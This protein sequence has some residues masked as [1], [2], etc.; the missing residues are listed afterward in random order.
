MGHLERMLM[1]LLWQRGELN[2]RQALEGVDRPLAYTTV[3]TTLDRLFKKGLLR[4]R[5]QERA[6][7]YSPCYTRQE[8]D[9]RR[10]QNFLGRFLSG[11]HQGGQVLISCLV[12]AVGKEDE[13]L[14]DE[15]EL[16]IQ[17]KRRELSEGEAS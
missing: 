8:W 7:V 11:T 13:A 9:R 14:L 17:A 3:M 5:K 4:R 10:A 16:R 15:L 12:D 1:E 2:A 6:F